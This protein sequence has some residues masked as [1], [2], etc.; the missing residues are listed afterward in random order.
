MG[1]FDK[2]LLKVFANALNNLNL[3][4][5]LIVNSQDGLDEISPYA[6]TNIVELDNG[7]IKEYVF[8]PKD[9][10]INTGSFENI[11]GKDPEYN[12]Q[13]LKRY[14]KEKIMIFQKLSL[15]CHNWSISF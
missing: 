4:K 12:S 14:L 10:N 7:I 3:T 1:V 15:E 2:S 11:V 9:F 6:K 5:A 13:K 8:N